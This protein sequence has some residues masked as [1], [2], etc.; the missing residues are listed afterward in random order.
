[1]GAGARAR[2]RLDAKCK[3][4]D[5]IADYALTALAG[6]RIPTRGSHTCAKPQHVRTRAACNGRSCARAMHLR[7]DIGLRSNRATILRSSEALRA[8]GKSE[9]GEGGRRAVPVFIE[10]YTEESERGARV[11]VRTRA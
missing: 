3:R 9:W 2:A 4:P 6:A 7:R 8:H 10:G 11:P 1:M 5:A